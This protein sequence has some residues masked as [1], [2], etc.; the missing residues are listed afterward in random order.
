MREELK[1]ENIRRM[2]KV[3]NRK[4]IQKFLLEA[5]KG[6]QEIEMSELNLQ[7]ED[8]ALYLIYVYLYGYSKE[9]DTSLV[10][11]HLNLL[12]KRVIHFL[13]VR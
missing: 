10:K 13:I 7:N 4:K 3:M 12:H 2:E 5:M 6:R 11:S 9:L 1:A 8:D